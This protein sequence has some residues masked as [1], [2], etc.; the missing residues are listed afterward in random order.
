MLS[1][2]SQRRRRLV[3]MVTP[4]LL[5]AVVAVG[6][7]GP[8][9]DD[10]TRLVRAADTLARLDG[11]PAESRGAGRAARAAYLLA[12]HAAQDAMRGDRMAVVAERL[13]TLGER[14]LARHLRRASAALPSTGAT[15]PP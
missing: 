9:E 13:E 12:F 7:G 8:A 5:L 3:A 1:S 11:S 6:A 14:E 2:P 15:P 4:A 10:W